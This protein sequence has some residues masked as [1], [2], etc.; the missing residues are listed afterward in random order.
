MFRVSLV[1]KRVTCTSFLVGQGLGFRGLCG[2]I[3]CCRQSIVGPENF[4]AWYRAL[5]LI[6]PS[7]EENTPE[8]PRPPYRHGDTEPYTR[9]AP[10]TTKSLLAFGPFFVSCPGLRGR[11]VDGTHCP[12]GLAVGWVAVEE[13]QIKLL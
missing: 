11:E 9:P 10:K 5:C 2:P 8:A 6:L 7:P 12:K 4:S 1:A 3:L 13:F